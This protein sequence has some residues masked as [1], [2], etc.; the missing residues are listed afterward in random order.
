METRVPDFAQ[1]SVIDMPELMEERYCQI[2]KILK[3]N[4]TI[5]PLTDII[6]SHEGRPIGWHETHPT[7]VQETDYAHLSGVDFAKLATIAAT[8]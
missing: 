3:E 4:I 2:C 7:D 6:V 5:N 8:G 1:K